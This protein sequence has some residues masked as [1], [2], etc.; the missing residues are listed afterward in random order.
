VLPTEMHV[1]RERIVVSYPLS[2]AVSKVL[3]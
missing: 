2:R 1:R 3:I